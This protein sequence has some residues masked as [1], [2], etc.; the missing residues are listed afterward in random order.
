MSYG[1]I[2]RCLVDKERIDELV[3]DGEVLFFNTAF[4]RLN[5]HCLVQKAREAELV[6][7]GGVV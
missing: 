2:R 1:L 5:L 4:D 6:S 7:D 3:S